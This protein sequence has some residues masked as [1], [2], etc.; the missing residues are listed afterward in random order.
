MLSDTPFGHNIIKDYV[1]A[2]GTLFN[3]IRAVRPTGSSDPASASSTTLAVPLTYSPKRVYLRTT[4]NPKLDSGVSTVLPR[5]S[6]EL[7]SM[8]YAADRKLNTINRYVG[9][10]S[11]SNTALY[12]TYTPV[13]YDLNFSLHIYVKNIED[14]TSII[15]Q[16]LPY[17][18]PE[19]TITLKGVTTMNLNQDV[20][21]VLTAVNTE[22][23]Y[24]EGFSTQRAI[25][26]S[27]D[28]TIKAN[29]FGPVLDTGIINKVLI[30]MYPTSNTSANTYEQSITKPAMYANGSPTTNADASVPLAEISANSDFGISKVITNIIG[31]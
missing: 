6:F 23:N 11:D 22:D 10:R 30:N 2:F 15:E 24:E 28:F 14:G 20:P 25:V 1:V 29:L 4:I 21:V 7:T 3:N 18:T 16:I 31:D 9:F 17:F 8:N 12:A 13:P 26:W 5:M 27:L 19:F